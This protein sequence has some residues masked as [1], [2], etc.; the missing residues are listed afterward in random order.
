[1]STGRYLVLYRVLRGD[2]EVVRVVH[3]AQFLPELFEE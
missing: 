3:G 2:V 1:M